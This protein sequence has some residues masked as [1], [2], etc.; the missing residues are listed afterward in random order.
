[1]T[2]EQFITA[3]RSIQDRFRDMKLVPDITAASQEE[4][5][6]GQMTTHR[7]IYD[8]VD[9]TYAAAYCRAAIDVYMS[10]K[11]KGDMEVELRNFVALSWV[12]TFPDWTVLDVKLF[13]WLLMRGLLPTT[14]FSGNEVRFILTLDMQGWFDKFWAYEDKRP[15]VIQRRNKAGIERTVNSSGGDTDYRRRPPIWEIDPFYQTHD[16][17]GKQMPENWNYKAYWAAK[18]TSEEVDEYCPNLRPKVHALITDKWQTQRKNNQETIE[19]L[20]D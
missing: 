7:Y 1:M 14:T 16:W 5:T 10:K 8:G 9:L 6:L 19:F 18:P 3:G 11:S 12:K 13:I 4:L 17:S 15:G 20:N 2:I